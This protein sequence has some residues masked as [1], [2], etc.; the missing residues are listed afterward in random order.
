MTLVVSSK[1]RVQAA[2]GRRL[3]L[4]LLVNF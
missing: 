1:A 3:P 2:Q 4:Y